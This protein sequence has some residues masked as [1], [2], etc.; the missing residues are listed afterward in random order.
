MEEMNLRYI[1]GAISATIF[2][3]ELVGL[4]YH[5]DQLGHVG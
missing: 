1:L 4:L 3:I 5:I 2:S